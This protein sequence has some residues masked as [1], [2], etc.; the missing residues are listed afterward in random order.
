M[1]LLLAQLVLAAHAAVIAFNVLGPLWCRKR[2]RWRA[3]HLAC[4]GS[5]LIFFAGAGRCPLTDAERALRGEERAADGFIERRL[6]SFVYWDVR[7]GHVGLATGLWFALWSF[8]YGR[9]W[10]SERSR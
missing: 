1:K 4:L 2:P 9:R 5:T 10:I 6:E 8:V 7:P 3:A